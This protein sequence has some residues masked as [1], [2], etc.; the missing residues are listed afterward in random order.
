MAELYSFS[1]YKESHWPCHYELVSTKMEAFI[2]SCSDHKIYPYNVI[3]SELPKRVLSAYTRR[4]ESQSNRLFV[5]AHASPQ[6][7]LPESRAVDILEF[8][9]EDNGLC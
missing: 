4:L 1:H 9:R 3:F 6:R 2:Q 7:K 8:H 5:K